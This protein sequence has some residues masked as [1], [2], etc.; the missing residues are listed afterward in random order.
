MVLSF[1][2]LEECWYYQDLVELVKPLRRLMGMKLE[3]KAGWD[4]SRHIEQLAAYCLLVMDYMA[5]VHWLSSNTR[6]SEDLQT[7][8][9][10]TQ[11]VQE[12]SESQTQFERGP[13]KW[14]EISTPY[15]RGNSVAS[16]VTEDSGDSHSTM[17]P[18]TFHI[19]PQSEMRGPV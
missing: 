18:T 2:L 14:F 9:G 8:G 19:S 3:G 12:S 7:S 13:R 10:G 17:D 4:K 5:S 6:R 11:A 16:G 1:S 15:Y